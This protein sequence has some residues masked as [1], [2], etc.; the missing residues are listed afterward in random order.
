M[1]A[2]HDNEKPS[3]RENSRFYHFNCTSSLRWSRLVEKRQNLHDTTRLRRG[4]PRSPNTAAQFKT[5]HHFTKSRASR[6]RRSQEFLS[7]VQNIPRI[8]NRNSTTQRNH[9]NGGIVP[10]TWE[11][12][13][14]FVKVLQVT[15]IEAPGG[16][17]SEP[18]IPWSSTPLRAGLGYSDTFYS[19]WPIS[20]DFLRHH[21]V[22]YGN[23]RTRRVLPS[24]ESRRVCVAYFITLEKKDGADRWTDARPLHFAFRYT[25]PA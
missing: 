20:R 18:W 9:S 4:E 5:A 14:G 15:L 8:F 25:R 7:G 23:T 10:T 11:L 17:G 22:T 24:G 19:Y 2:G 13:I 6:E 3:W 12:F 21:V 1:S 16:G